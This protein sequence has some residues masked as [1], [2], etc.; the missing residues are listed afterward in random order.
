[1]NSGHSPSF[2]KLNCNNNKNALLS[3][4]FS[5]TVC[6][7]LTIQIHLCQTQTITHKVCIA[8]LARSDCVVENVG[9]DG[10]WANDGHCNSI[11]HHF[12]LQRHEV[13]LHIKGLRLTKMM[14][15]AYDPQTHQ[16][17]MCLLY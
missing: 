15:I 4:V 11:P 12:G 8:S 10:R 3:I 6:S 7:R 17:S 16:R 14:G 9:V 13:V 5:V 2:A 1:M